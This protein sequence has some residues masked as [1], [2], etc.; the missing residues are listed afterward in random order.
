MA[1]STQSTTSDMR[2]QLATTCPS[3]GGGIE[4]EVSPE[5]RQIECGH[6]HMTLALAGQPT[7]AGM[8]DR[9]LVCPSRDLFVRKDFPQRLG[10]TIVAVGFV[11]SSI[12]WYYENFVATYG[13]LFATALL[14]VLVYVLRGN[15]LECYACHA[16]YR[17]A[18][19]AEH[20]PFNL[21]IHERHRQQR[22][23]MKEAQQSAERPV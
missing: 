6:C 13:I 16:Q 14:D 22:A 8:M 2:V 4:V 19:L 18:S 15:L 20:P 12:A 7:A 5:S 11:A 17:Q 21:E 1:A 23:R 9:C 10:V 3:C